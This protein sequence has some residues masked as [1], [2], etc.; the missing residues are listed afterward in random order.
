[1]TAAIEVR[2]LRVQRGTHL[3]LR[4]LTLDVEA[5]SITGLLG[6]SGSGK[7]TLLRAI[8]GTQ[9]VT[10]GSVRVLG[11]TAGD[12]ELRHRIGYVTQDASVYGDLTVAENARYF[13]TV[14]GAPAAAAAAAIDVVGL[15]AHRGQLV[16]SLSGGERSRVS[17]ACALVGSP[18]VLVLDEPT[19]GLDPVLRAELWA[20]FGTL[21]DQGRT[22]VVSSHVMNEADRCDQLLLLREGE[23][24]GAFPPAGLRAAGGTDDLD[25]A[26][27]AVIHRHEAEVA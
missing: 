16:D 7:T 24:L 17:L 9:I 27:L 11:L 8:V 20:T 22:L 3:A 12:P 6:P 23:L 2:D 1:M 25:D 26:F 4:G 19:V 18:D 14:A 10:S 5:G 15:S 13:A 21:R